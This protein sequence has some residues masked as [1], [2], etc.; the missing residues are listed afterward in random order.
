MSLTR[1]ELES[2]HRSAKAIERLADYLYFS[3]KLRSDQ[4]KAEAS[5]IKEKVESVIGQQD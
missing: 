2:I 1:E 4:I 5:S 3:N